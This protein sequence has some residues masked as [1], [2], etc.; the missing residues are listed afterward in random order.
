MLSQRSP[1]NERN[2]PH[3]ALA[4]PES[5]IRQRLSEEIPRTTPPAR[6]G[7]IRSRSYL[8]SPDDTKPR[9]AVTD[10]IATGQLS[11]RRS[12]KEDEPAITLFPRIH[13]PG[14]RSRHSH[15]LRDGSVKQHSALHPHR[16]HRHTQSELHAPYRP[17]SSTNL[18]D[19]DPLANGNLNMA[20]K[21]EVPGIKAN[22]L[23]RM[24]SNLSSR[25][26]T[27]KPQH[28]YSSSDLQKSLPLSRPDLRRRATSDP[29]SPTQ[30]LR[31]LQDNASTPQIRLDPNRLVLPQQQP[32][33][34]P[35]TEVESL[36]LRA[37][38]RKVLSD[39][40]VS[41]SDVQ[42]LTTQLAESN[43]EIQSHLSS[44]TRVAS[45]LMRRL[46]DAQDTLLRTATS[47]TDTISSF[48]DLNTQ[49]EALVTNFGKK[50]LHLDDGF[51]SQ[52]EKSRL[53]LFEERGARVT[54]LEVRGQAAS[55][56]AQA[57]S[58]RLDNCRVILDNFEQREIK[59]RRAR[60][61]VI[62]GSLWGCAMI[63]LGLIL[64]FCLWWWKSYS[65]IVRYDVHEA[66]ALMLDHSGQHKDTVRARLLESM[67]EHRDQNETA[68]E[69][70][71][72]LPD[73]IREL[74]DDIAK[75]HGVGDD[76]HVSN[77]VGQKLQYRPV[78]RDN[79]VEIEE[80]K[81]KTL[82][83]KLEL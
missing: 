68:Q 15:D 36:L 64:G 39:L 11:Q 55:Q 45:N 20:D 27:N 81:L 19:A 63:L 82:F 7:H 54:Q 3:P 22:M 65:E 59:K 37:E 51:K 9:N 14:H 79:E 46:D 35:L 62:V 72:N 31:A 23:T 80:K 30:R 4:A 29:R 16:Q 1:H 76:G 18:R 26:S 34:K 71:K 83:E 57:L 5:P 67:K 40:N 43:V 77:G 61:D 25:A 73:D 78:G 13:L 74:L 75:R 49:S 42:L 58:Q 8:S 60:R 12:T 53:A 47:L 24:A 70:F 56:K 38:K 10:P 44:S 41:E 52:I 21:L 66:V 6:P 50:A 69:V 28:Q 2:T 32:P 17:R 33:S 48:H